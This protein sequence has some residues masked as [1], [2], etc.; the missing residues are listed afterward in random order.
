MSHIIVNSYL[1]WSLSLS[2]GN[3]AFP[4]H[5]ITSLHT[6]FVD[7]DVIAFYSNWDFVLPELFVTL[8]HADYVNFEDLLVYLHWDVI[9]P[10]WNFELSM[11]VTDLLDKC[12]VSYVI[13]LVACLTA[14]VRE[15]TCSLTRPP[16][17][18]GDWTLFSSLL[19]E[20]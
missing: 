15:R 18:L 11:L 5:Y 13:I 9:I 4:D 7:C 20:D 8:P 3:N 1:G 2:I 16:S 17:I 14:M 10:T 6:H 19:R 12:L